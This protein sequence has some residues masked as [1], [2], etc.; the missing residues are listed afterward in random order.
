[1]RKIHVVL[2]KEEIDEQKISRC[3]AVA[4]RKSAGARAVYTASLLNGKAVADRLLR[5]PGEET[6]VLGNHP[7]QASDVLR[8]TRVGHFIAREGMGESTVFASQ[9]GILP[10]IPQLVNGQWVH[11]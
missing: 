10:V 3:T 7:A 5:Q 11:R 4:I 2:R 8:A 6:F 1:M 9:K